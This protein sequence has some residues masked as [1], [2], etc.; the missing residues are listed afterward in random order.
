MMRLALF[1]AL[2]FFRVSSFVLQESLGFFTTNCYVK[3]FSRGSSLIRHSKHGGKPKMYLMEL[4]LGLGDYTL[5]RYQASWDRAGRGGPT[6]NHS[7]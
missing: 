2:C 5:N 7:G 3:T 6:I 4:D 1:R